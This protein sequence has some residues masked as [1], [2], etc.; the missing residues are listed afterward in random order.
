VTAPLF[1]DPVHDGAT[2]PVLVHHADGTWWMFYTQHGHLVCD[3]DEDLT[4]ALP[5]GPPVR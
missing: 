5:A 4:L 2:D 1:R 3:R